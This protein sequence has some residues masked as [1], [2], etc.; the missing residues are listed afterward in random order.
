[1]KRLGLLIV[2]IG[3]SSL[4]FSQR[5]TPQIQVTESDTLFCFSLLQSKLIAKL[6]ASSVFCDSLTKHY[7]HYLS[8]QKTQITTKD[9][10]ITQLEQKIGNLNTINVHHSE[11][12]QTMNNLI[13]VKDK[14]IRKYKWQKRILGVVTGT[15]TVILIMK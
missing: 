6:M 11:I 13:Q 3:I 9:S 5:L 15:L 4:S 7:Q 12:N 2:W 8:L 1:M 14:A 10:T